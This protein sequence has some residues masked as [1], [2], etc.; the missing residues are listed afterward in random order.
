MAFTL[1][2]ASSLG[3]N[4]VG[5][6]LDYAQR[7]GHFAGMKIRLTKAIFTLAALIMVSCATAPKQ[8]P[9]PQPLTYQEKQAFAER[10]KEPQIFGLT[11]YGSARGPVFEGAFRPRLNSVGRLDFAD[12]LRKKPLVMLNEKGPL[13][14]IDTA[15]AESWLR[16]Q[17]AVALG[18][19][20][21]GGPQLFERRA[22]HVPD[23]VG[24]FAVLVSALQLENARMDNAIFYT[25]NTRGRLQWLDRGEENLPVDGVLGADALRGFEF[26]RISLSGGKMIFSGASVYPYRENAMTSVPLIDVNGGLGVLCRMEGEEVEAVLDVAGDFEVSMGQPDQAVIRQLSI[27]DLVFR[28]VSNIPAAKL[29]LPDDSPPRIGR[30]LLERYDLVINQHGQEILF[31]KPTL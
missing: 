18:A 9:A 13:M 6:A 24:G 4:E 28:Q 21:L 25:R 15:S 27:G 26:V 12:R 11:P 7:R 17:T 8:P 29:G 14:L 1:A 2:K 30:A 5:F 22:S 31:E 10:A 19:Q 23:P 16:V 3:K 20:P